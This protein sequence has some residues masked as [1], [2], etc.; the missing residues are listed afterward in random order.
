[1]SKTIGVIYDTAT[2][3]PKRVIFPHDDSHLTNGIHTPQA[4]ES[5][6][7]IPNSLVVGMNATEAA[8]FAIT[9]KTGR[10]P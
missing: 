1:M 3:A 9:H 2:L 4:G 7:I 6:S 5:I 8:K 10:I